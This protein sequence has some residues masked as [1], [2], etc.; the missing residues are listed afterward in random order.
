MNFL[1]EHGDNLSSWLLILQT[2]Y[3]EA[4][5]KIRSVAKDVFPE[6]E[7]L[8]TSP[9]QQATVYLASREKHLKRPVSVW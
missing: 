9:T 5:D 6:L 7:D 8:F 1:T 3:R 4:F 2:R